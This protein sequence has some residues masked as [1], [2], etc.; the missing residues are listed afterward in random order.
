MGDDSID[1]VISHI[2]MGYLVTL[3]TLLHC[4]VKPEPILVTKTTKITQ[5][6]CQKVLTSSRTVDECKPLHA[7][8]HGADGHSA[9]HLLRHGGR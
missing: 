7:G 3:L 8:C 2:D 9:V 4:S 5:R 6:I 1:M